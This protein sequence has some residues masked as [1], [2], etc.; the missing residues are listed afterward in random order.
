MSVTRVV[1]AGGGTAGWMAAAA[2]ARTMGR[3][4]EVTLVESEAIGTVG[5]GEST[6]PPLVTYNRLLGINEAEFMAATAATFKLGIL[7]DGWHTPDSRYFHSFGTTGRDHWAAGFQHYWLNGRTRGHERPY[8]DYCTELVAALQGKFAHLPGDATN[9]AYQL[10]SGRYAQ[11]LR[12]MAERDG[13]QRVEG[14]IARVELD[15]ETGDIAALLLDGDRRIEGDLF[16]DCTGFRAL[17]IEGTLHAG[18]DDWTHW[19][20]CDAAIAV[21]TE[22]VGPPLP[23]TRAM[24]HDAGWQWRIPLQHRVGNGIVYCSRYLDRDGALDRLMGNVEGAVRTEPNFLRFTTGARRKQWHRNC[25]AIGLSGGFME[26]LESTSIH[27]IQRAV[28]RLLRLF[29]QGGIRPADV[30]EFND[31]QLQDMEQIR[32][33]LILH[34]KVT[35][36]RDSPF[37]R[38][39]AA[40]DVP[41]TLQQKIDLFRQSGRVFRRN[42]EL[43]G[44]NSWVQVMMGQGIVP[45]GYHPIA[46]KLSDAELDR[47]LSM[48]RRQVAD[49]V[50]TMPP[51]GDY[52]ARYC[53]ADRP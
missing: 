33:F 2:I 4:V 19:L 15:G 9:Y 31:Q 45:E 48:I 32:D 6:I 37:W 44:E 16:L 50:A 25:V 8:D 11:F 39:C 29:P 22:S 35:D 38:Q 20:P 36:R 27:L 49:T 41:T 5:V 53:P 13:T 47:L 34:Y 23:Y 24:A 26:P 12:N 18:F 51:H 52:V 1:I 10:D 42:E 46:D 28:L 40:M 3:M 14:R 7:F 17:L 30:A 21:Q 43:F